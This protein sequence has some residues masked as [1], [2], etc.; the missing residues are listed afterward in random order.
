MRL[1]SALI[2]LIED[3]WY[4]GQDINPDTI[5]FGG[6]C[7]ATLAFP[8]RPFNPVCFRPVELSLVDRPVQIASP[9]LQPPHA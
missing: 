5:A 4:F 8:S 9:P 3:G 7:Y 1:G 6:R 2:P